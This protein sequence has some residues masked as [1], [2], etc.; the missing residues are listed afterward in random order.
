MLPVAAGM[1]V[2]LVGAWYA[3]RLMGSLLAG[4]DPHEPRAYAAVVLALVFAALAA[5]VLPA[6]RAASVDPLEVLRTE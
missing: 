3:T 1:A 4:V 6:L 2:G 5:N